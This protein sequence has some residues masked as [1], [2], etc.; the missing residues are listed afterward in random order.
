MAAAAQCQAWQYL[1]LVKAIDP[2]IFPCYSTKC[3][4]QAWVSSKSPRTRLGGGGTDSGGGGEVMEPTGGVDS[5]GMNPASAAGILAIS[6]RRT[7]AEAAASLLGTLQLPAVPRAFQSS[8]MAAAALNV[9]E[10]SLVIVR[11]ALCVGGRSACAAATRE[12]NL[13]CC[14]RRY[15]RGAWCEGGAWTS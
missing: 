13:P 14:T 6:A 9:V 12:S 7:S 2:L 15:Y 11:S 1:G 4:G 8:P 5:V 10:R 3:S